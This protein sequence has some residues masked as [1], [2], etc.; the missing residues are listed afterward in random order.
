MAALTYG[1]SEVK[2]PPKAFDAAA[3]HEHL[4]ALRVALRPFPDRV[5]QRIVRA[6]VGASESRCDT[7]AAGGGRVVASKILR[8]LCH[9]IAH[10]CDG[11]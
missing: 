5:A 2:P 11:H 7:N 1:L 4:P 10:I 3:D 6:N 9:A 8:D